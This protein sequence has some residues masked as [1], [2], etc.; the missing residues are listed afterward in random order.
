MPENGGNGN[1]DGSQEGDGPMQAEFDAALAAAPDRD[2]VDK[3]A[4]Y[5]TMQ[6]ESLRRAIEAQARAMFD[7][8]ELLSERFKNI[9]SEI[10]RL[11]AERQAGGAGDDD[12]SG[13]LQ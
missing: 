13:S 11:R 9:E 6:S 4:V 10:L 3:L 5:A 12:E 8:A 2:R 1:G 7:L